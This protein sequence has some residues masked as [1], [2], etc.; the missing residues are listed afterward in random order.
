M[1]SPAL[2]PT[3][4]RRGEHYS[5]ATVPTT[6]ESDTYF[7]SSTNEGDGSTLSVPRNG[8]GGSMGKPGS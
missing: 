4:T 6:E 1:P 8:A 5:Y 7:G 3:T 2:G